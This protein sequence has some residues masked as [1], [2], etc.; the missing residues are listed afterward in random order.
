[1]KINQKRK[2][3]RQIKTFGKIIT[4]ATIAITGLF[5]VVRIADAQTWVEIQ[6]QIKENT[7]QINN[8]ENKIIDLKENYKLLYEGLKNQNEQLGNQISFASYFLGIVSAL[9]TFGGIFLAWFI[10]RQYDK[11]KNMSDIVGSTKKYIDEH[12]KEL[13][14][15]IKRDETIDLLNRLKEVPEDVSNI[16]S[17]LLSR[18]LLIEDYEDLKE[19][20]SKVKEIGFPGNTKYEYTMILLQHFPYQS[21]KDAE[22]KIDIIPFINRHSLNNMFDGDTRHLFKEVFRY[23]KEF[24]ISN[25]QNKTIIKNLFYGCFNSRF[26]DNKDLQIL[27]KSTTLEFRMNISDISAIAKEQDL[28][29]QAYLTWIDSIYEN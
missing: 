3:S 5:F 18:D 13:Y 9:F 24:G 17:V 26:K 22:L 4:G 25:E 28:G 6:D 8:I 27:I 12:N 21:L 14:K 2:N 20:Y 10:N 7:Q 16:C 11:I 15:K 23:L 29:N 1:M 19:S